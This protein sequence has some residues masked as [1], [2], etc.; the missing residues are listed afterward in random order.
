MVLPVK[1]SKL[2]NAAM[3]RFGALSVRLRDRSLRRIEKQ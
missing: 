1:T 3:T 2:Q